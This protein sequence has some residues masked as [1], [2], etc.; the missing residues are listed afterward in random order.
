MSVSVETGKGGLI[1]KSPYSQEFVS[2][3]RMRNGRWSDKLEAWLFDERDEIAVRSALIDIYGTDDYA[4]CVK[5]DLLVNISKIYDTRLVSKACVFGWPIVDRTGGGYLRLGTKDVKTVIISGG[6]P[7]L[8]LWRGG[9]FV[10]DAEENTVVV[11]RDIPLAIAQRFIAEHPEDAQIIG[12]IN[13]AQLKAEK[14]LLLKRLAEIDHL[15]ATWEE[16]PNV[17]IDEYAIIADLSDDDDD[18][19][20]GCG[21]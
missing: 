9:K 11:A 16:R 3:A 15:I 8:G 19:S 20:E 14:E 10:L 17:E 2:F 6:F 13:I 18:S 1:V 4:S 12:N 5:C 7:K 21:R